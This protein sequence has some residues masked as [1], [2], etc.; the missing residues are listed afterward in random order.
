ME[1]MEVFQEN[2]RL[3]WG[4]LTLLLFALARYY[5]FGRL[6]KKVTWA[7]TIACGGLFYGLLGYAMDNGDITQVFPPYFRAACYIVV[8]AIIGGRV[9]EILRWVK[10]NPVR[11]SIWAAIIIL[12]P[13]WWHIALGALVI[14]AVFYGLSLI[15]ISGVPFRALTWGMRHAAKH[16]GKH[17]A[18]HA[19]GKGQQKGWSQERYDEMERLGNMSN[20]TPHQEE[21]YRALLNAYS[22]YLGGAPQKTAP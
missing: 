12:F 22:R 15:P 13:L 4:G 5:D 10:N 2:Q 18:K 17:V 1:F 3:I 14:Y 19:F 6:G 20:R 8:A 9:P 16:G 11:A 7:I 21:I